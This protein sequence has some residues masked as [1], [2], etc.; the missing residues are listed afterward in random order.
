MASPPEKPSPE[1]L[2]EYIG[3]R[4]VNTAIAFIVLEIVLVALRFWVRRAH[5][6]KFGWDDYLILPSLAFCISLC[7]VGIRKS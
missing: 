7:I 6:S 5:R 3:D 1:F 4:L 2:S